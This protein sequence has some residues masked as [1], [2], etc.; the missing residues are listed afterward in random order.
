MLPINFSN[1][2]EHSTLP[3]WLKD[4]KRLLSV[5]SSFDSSALAKAAANAAQI[6]NAEIVVRTQDRG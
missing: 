4:W 1:C 6:S 3:C 5:A 2:T